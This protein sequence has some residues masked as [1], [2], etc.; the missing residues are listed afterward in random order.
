MQHVSIPVPRKNSNPQQTLEW[1]IQLFTPT[2]PYMKRLVFNFDWDEI[3]PR[4]DINDDTRRELWATYDSMTSLEEFV[5]IGE[6]H[7]T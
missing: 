5:G 3:Q 7:S 1:V 6:M 2:G 4:N